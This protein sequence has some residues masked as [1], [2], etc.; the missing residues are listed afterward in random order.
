MKA[1]G[2]RRREEGK[3]GEGKREEEKS[4]KDDS[5]QTLISKIHYLIRHSVY[6]TIP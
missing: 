3:E 1:V 2:G 4:I 6:T 5:L